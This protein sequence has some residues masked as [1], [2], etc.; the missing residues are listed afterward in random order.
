LLS[1]VVRIILRRGERMPERFD[2]MIA[3]TLA[4]GAES[5]HE[6]LPADFGEFGSRRIMFTRCLA[7]LLDRYPAIHVRVSGDQ[8]AL[9][10]MGLTPN[11][12]M[13]IGTQIV[14]TTL[15]S[16]SLPGTLRLAFKRRSPG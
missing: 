7:V 3:E 12:E 2:K 8:A 6:V 4:T 1:T 16:T 15:A 14:R 10:N 5:H 13:L 11:G 9:I